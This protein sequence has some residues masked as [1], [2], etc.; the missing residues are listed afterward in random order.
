MMN[1]NT[2]GGK[3]H[4]KQIS[5]IIVIPLHTAHGWA[6][7]SHLTLWQPEFV[8][9]LIDSWVTSRL[10]VIL[11]PQCRT[12]LRVLPPPPPHSLP[13]H[14]TSLWKF[15]LWGEVKMWSDLS[16]EILTLGGMVCFAA[17]YIKHK[18][19]NGNKTSYSEGNITYSYEF[20]ILLL[21]CIQSLQFQGFACSCW[22]RPQLALHPL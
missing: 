15:Y 19:N 5:D 16:G 14:W 20:Y 10:K 6:V 3:P 12:N 9:N 22:R 13:H 1:L 8:I 18:L 21:F 4:M 2:Q 17:M 11:H 7:E